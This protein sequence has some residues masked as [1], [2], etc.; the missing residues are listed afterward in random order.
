MDAA[1]KVSGSVKRSSCKINVLVT[2]DLSEKTLS[3]LA[4]ERREQ[5]KAALQSDEWRRVFRGKSI[6]SSFVSKYGKNLNY[7]T[8]RDMVVNTM[9]EEG[10][11]P[12]GM[13]KI[14]AAIDTS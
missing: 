12:S 8:M 6:L 9:A 10:F 7:Q 11:R 14:L 2:T 13:L 1:T 5:L 4:S 3:E